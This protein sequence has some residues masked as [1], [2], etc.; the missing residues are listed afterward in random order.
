M[1]KFLIVDD[2]QEMLLLLKLILSKHGE[3]V[4]AESGQNALQEFEQAHREKKP[5]HL[6]FLDIMMPGM[7]GHE[8]LRSIRALEQNKY[9]TESKA[10]IAMLTALGS[11]KSRFS[12]YEE[13]CEYYL[14]K[15]LIKAEIIKII[16]ETEEWFAL[17]TN[18]PS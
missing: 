14:V 3:C 18:T 8:V 12:S 9:S 11:P 15:P 7:D 6:V 17:F 1:L 10:K 5:F 16:R 4:T 13:G 2:N